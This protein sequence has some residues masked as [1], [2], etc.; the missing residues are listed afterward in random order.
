MSNDADNLHLH[1]RHELH[2]KTIIL[3]FNNISQYYNFLC[4][5]KCKKK[6]H[7]DPKG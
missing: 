3:N 1:H 4:I 7:T 5:F 2:Y 6:N